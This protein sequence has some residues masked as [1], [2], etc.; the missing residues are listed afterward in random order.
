MTVICSY[1]H[2]PTELVGSKRQR[3]RILTLGRFVYPGTGPA[4]VTLDGGG[5]T[6][7]E[8]THPPERPNYRLILSR[9]TT[10]ISTSG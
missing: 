7:L 4:R 3:P 10:R 6:K 2:Q 5:W 8:T 9:V 1:C